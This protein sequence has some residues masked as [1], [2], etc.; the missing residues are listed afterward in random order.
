MKGLT[1]CVTGV[2]VASFCP[3]AVQA[4]AAG[5]PLYLVLGAVAGLLPDTLDFKVYRF[6]APHDVEIIPDPSRPDARMIAGGV[7]AAVGQAAASGR[8]VRLKLAAVLTGGSQ[9]QAYRVTFDGTRREVVA[10]YPDDDGAGGG[11]VRPCDVGQPPP[12]HIARAPL[13]CPVTLDYT[14]A[15]DVRMFD[16]PLLHLEPAP[17]GRVH[18]R[19]LPW[20]RQWSHSLVTAAALGLAAGAAWGLLAGVVT[21]LAAAA[22]TALDQLGFMGSNLFF[23]FTRHRTP[24]CQWRE[25]SDTLANFGFI[26][27]ACLLIFWNLARL[28]PGSLHPVPLMP[29]L[30][31]G[32]GIPVA[33]VGL[34]RRWLPR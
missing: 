11:N 8:T 26:W 10:E 6:F 14:A 28:T 5:N 23:P 27:T 25:S 1:H 13:P 34:L 33:L 30:L 31:Y 32:A 29:L 19:F 9:W 2:A 21:A 17:D 12:R 15:M 4:A 18:V 20:H 3:G 7:A 24:G 22:H 16:G